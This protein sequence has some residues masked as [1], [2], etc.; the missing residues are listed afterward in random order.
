MLV[1]HY[2]TELA[3]HLFLYYDENP[4]SFSCVYL[5]GHRGKHHDFNFNWNSIVVDPWREFK[6]DGLGIKQ[7]IYYGN[8]R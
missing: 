2:V 8:T 7:I 5:L 6:T 4:P 1:G 3:P